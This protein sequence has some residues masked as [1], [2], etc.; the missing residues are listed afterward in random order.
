MKKAFIIHG[1]D[2]SPQEP[3]HQWLKEELIKDGY[4]VYV[5]SMPHPEAPTIKEWVQTIINKVTEASAPD[6]E[7]LFIGHSVGCQAVLRATEEIAEGVEIGGIVLIA[8][9]M[10]LDKQT[11]E[12]EGEEVVEIARPW[13]E[14]PINFEKI[15]SHTNNIFAVFSDNDPYVPVSQK[16]LFEKE[17]GAKTI[18]LE[19]YGHF[20][21]A[22]NIREVSPVLGYIKSL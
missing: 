5:P 22:D 12:E 7:T 6:K 14:T 11:I 10:E 1:W 4:E 9:W 15:K 13:M 18:V 3:M 2:G 8:P 19:G 21:P 17:L 20:S 16:D